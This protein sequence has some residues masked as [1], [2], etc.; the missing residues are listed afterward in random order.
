MNVV[1][2]LLYRQGCFIGKYTTRKAHT[3]LHSGRDDAF[4]IHSFTTENIDDVIS[5][6]FHGCLSVFLYNI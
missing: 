1:F 4:A 5:R 2:L 3:K 6:F